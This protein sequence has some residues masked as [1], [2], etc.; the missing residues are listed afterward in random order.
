MNSARSIPSFELATSTANPSVRFQFLAP[1]SS[2]KLELDRYTSR[3]FESPDN[4][5]ESIPPLIEDAITL[6]PRF[7]LNNDE[8]MSARTLNEDAPFPCVSCGKVF[9]TASVMQRMGEK[10]K[11]HWMFQNPEQRARLQMCEDCRV[12]DMFEREGGLTSTDRP[13]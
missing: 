2:E 7:L 3:W 11:D 10:L 13:S 4:V 1:I 5:D 12:K 8:R 6:T 9:A